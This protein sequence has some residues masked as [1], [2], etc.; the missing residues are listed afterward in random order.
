MNVPPTPQVFLYRNPGT[1]DLSLAAS[2][3]PQVEEEPPAPAQ[4]MKAFEAS[5]GSAVAAVAHLQSLALAGRA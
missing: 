3:F 2:M 5:G 1:V 4:L